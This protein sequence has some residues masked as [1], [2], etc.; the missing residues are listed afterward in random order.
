MAHG[1]KCYCCGHSPTSDAHYYCRNCLVK[2][3]NMFDTNSAVWSGVEY[4]ILESPHQSSHCV[5]CG[6]HENRRIIDALLICDKCVESELWEQAGNGSTLNTVGS[7]NGVIVKDEESVLGARI[8]L[9]KD[10]TS[11]PYAITCGIYG[12]FVHTAF[13]ENI[14]EANIKYDEMK[15]EMQAFLLAEAFNEADISDWCRE[16]ADRY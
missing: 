9:E 13:Y 16:F 4:E 1:L 12:L 2:L 3:K 10:G 15:R 8:T 7:E 11:S 14:I 6:Q 5:S